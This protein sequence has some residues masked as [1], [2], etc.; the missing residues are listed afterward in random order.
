MKHPVLKDLFNVKKQFFPKDGVET[1]LAPDTEPA[2]EPEKKPDIPGDLWA[3][4]NGCGR[5]LYAKLLDTNMK[6]CPMCAYHFRLTPEERVGYTFDQDTFAP[7][8]YD[9]PEPDPLRFPGYREK[10]ESSKTSTGHDDAVLC[11]VG[12]IKGTETAVCIMNSFFMMGSMGYVVGESITRTVEYATANRLP[13]VIFTCSGGARMQEGIV[14]LMQ[15]AK[16]SGALKKHSDAGLL[17]ITVITNP[18]TGGTASFASLGD[19]ILAEKGAL[20]G[21]AGKRVIEQTIKQKL[22]KD[23]QTAEFAMEHGFVDM[24]C[25][26]RQLRK[27]LGRLLALHAPEQALRGAEMEK[28]AEAEHE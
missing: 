3:K 7:L 12:K 21:F 2:A 22:P 19:I 23:F 15:M 13:I 25:E 24:I 8:T 9:I 10:L 6:V 26:R 18:T 28:E 1:A 5:A 16:I 27:T 17:Y 14:S 11:G 4:C 20:I